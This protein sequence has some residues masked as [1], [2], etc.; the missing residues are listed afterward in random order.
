MKDHNI[1]PKLVKLATE[2]P[3]EG[4]RRK[5]IR[6]ISSTARNY[7]PGLDGIISQIPSEQSIDGN[8]DA[9]DMGSVDIL[10]DKLRHRSDSMKQS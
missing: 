3:V 9:N 4:V 5:A 7:Q 2:D 10:I 6:A 1:I 8:L